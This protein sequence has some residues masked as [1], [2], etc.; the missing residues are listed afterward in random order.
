MGVLLLGRAP[1]IAMTR[2]TIRNFGLERGKRTSAEQEARHAAAARHGC[3]WVYCT[4]P[5]DG[6][7][8]WFSAPNLGEPFDSALSRAV[9]AEL[10]TERDEDEARE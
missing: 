4:I 2:Q 8:S 1:G 6:V 10:K 7:R 9:M 3:T 5:G